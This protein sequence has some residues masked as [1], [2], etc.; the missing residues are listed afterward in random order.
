MTRAG[1]DEG[2]ERRGRDARRKNVAIGVFA[3][4][5]V[6]SSGVA[7]A[8]G[9]VIPAR[10]PP[11]RRRRRSPGASLPQPTENALDAYEAATR[12]GGNSKTAKSLVS[13][14]SSGKKS[15]FDAREG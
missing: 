7:T 14:G 13:K 1:S 8:D 4:G 11:A 12:S 10:G 6:A 9:D 2:R 3:A 15:R 5:V